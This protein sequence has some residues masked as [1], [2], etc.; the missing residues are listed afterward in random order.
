MFTVL[1]GCPLL[2]L[3][4]NSGLSQQNLHVSAPGLKRTLKREKLLILCQFMREEKAAAVR[5]ALE[6]GWKIKIRYS[7]MRYKV[8]PAI[9]RWVV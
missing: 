2:L 7:R 4:T 6:M 3:L 8:V 1:F 9:R 5:E